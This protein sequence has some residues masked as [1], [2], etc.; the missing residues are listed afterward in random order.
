MTSSDTR[1][2]TSPQR[3][4]KV[5][6]GFF[7]TPSRYL[8]IFIT[9]VL[10]LWVWT[11]QAR[12]IGLGALDLYDEFYTLDRTTGFARAG[13]WLNVYTHNELNF[14]KPPLHYW[15]GG[16]LLDQGMDLPA[17]LRAPS[18]IF[19]L[20][21]LGA[22]ALLAAAI[23]PGNLWAVPVA[24]LFLSTSRRFWI[25][26]SQALLDTGAMF[27]VTMALAATILALRRPWWWYVVGLA[28]GLG[29][30]QKAPIAF[31]F[32]ALFLLFTGLTARWHGTGFRSFLGNRHFLTSML[33]AVGLWSSWYI[34]QVAQHGFVVL[35]VGFGEQMIDRFAPG[36][37]VSAKRSLSAVFDHLMGSEA[38]LRLPAVLALAILP[39]WLR[40]FDLLALP[41]MVLTYLAAVGFAEGGISMRYTLYIGSTLAVALAAVLVTLP[42]R[43]RTLTALILLLALAIGGPV[44]SPADLR[45]FPRGIRQLQVDMLTRLSEEQ[46]P[47]EQIVY[48]NWDPK[49]RIPPGAVS[50]YGSANRPYFRPDGP[51]GFAALVGSG[52]ISGP[53]RGICPTEYIPTVEPH[54]TGFQVIDTRPP[55]TYWTA[56]SVRPA[57]GTATGD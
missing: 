23:L 35:K 46:K 13:D 8:P 49:T 48:C 12:M 42:V 15:F 33:V 53:M 56:E 44:R 26:A 6:L 16:L 21:C 17:G 30:L 7:E 20:G 27:F 9:I 43:P 40:R 38:L 24:V 4:R 19:A 5:S 31:I 39:W 37:D 55:Y 18:M 10:I 45:L 34:F 14:R 2:E 36:A 50:Y 54:V 57:A 52:A 32:V 41:L 22:T 47:S 29:A 11:F 51:D 1:H 25:S 3:D 28:I